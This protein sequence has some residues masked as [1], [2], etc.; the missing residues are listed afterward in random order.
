M[1]CDFCG[2]VRG[3]VETSPWMHDVFLSSIKFQYRSLMQPGGHS[4]L[5]PSI[6][7]ALDTAPLSSIFRQ[8]TENMQEYRSNPYFSCTSESSDSTNVSLLRFEYGDGGI[9]K[10]LRW[11][12]NL[13]QSTW[14]HKML[15]ADIFRE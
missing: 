4:F 6:T 15:Y 2:F 10:L 13:H 9:F 12:Q 7:L 14:N 11:L 3:S 8:P 1:P 5:A